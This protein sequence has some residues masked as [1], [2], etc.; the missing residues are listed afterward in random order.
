MAGGRWHDVSTGQNRFPEHN[1]QRAPTKKGPS[2]LNQRQGTIHGGAGEVRGAGGWVPDP[3]CQASPDC[4]LEIGSPAGRGG[5]GCQVGVA[6]GRPP[7]PGWD[8]ARAR[9]EARGGWRYPGPVAGGG[10]AASRRLLFSKKSIRVRASVG[11]YMAAS[12]PV[13]TS[14]MDP[15]AGRR[16]AI[17]QLGAELTHAA[18]GACVPTSCAPGAASRQEITSRSKK[19]RAC[20]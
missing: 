19:S 6:G 18:I 15:H 13:T 2:G 3:P 14:L 11:L 12:R 4:A 16:V 1:A 10:A 17:Q 8:R 20:G 7:G 9:I 5:G